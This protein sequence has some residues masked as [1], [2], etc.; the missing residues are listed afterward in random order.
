MVVNKIDTILKFQCSFKGYQWCLRT[1][2]QD[3][4]ERCW[5]VGTE[6]TRPYH[7]SH[8][9]VTVVEFLS[10]LEQH[11]HPLTPCKERHLFYSLLPG[12]YRECIHT[13][14]NQQMTHKTPCSLSPDYK[15]R[16]KSESASLTLRKLAHCTGSALRPPTLINS[17][18][19]SF[20]PV[21]GNSFQSV[22]GPRHLQ[23]IFQHVFHCIW[24]KPS[25]HK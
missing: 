8:H 12:L 24:S 14:F 16:P 18:L 15:N 19:L 10:P 13:S 23:L 9:V 20:C 5:N 1:K 25:P 7:P 6:K 2:E 4:Q 11:G 3:E 17:I 21:F 22:H